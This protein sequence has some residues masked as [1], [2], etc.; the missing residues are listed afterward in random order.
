M[1]RFS[2]PR[3]L[4]PVSVVLA[5]LG[6][7][8]IAVPLLSN[9]G[10]G[11]SVVAATQAFVSA[12]RPSDRRLKGE[13]LGSRRIIAAIDQRP[14]QLPR[15]R[16]AQL[17]RL[18]L[19]L[20]DAA[21]DLEIARLSV[22]AAQPPVT[23]DIVRPAVKRFMPDPRRK[24]ERLK[25]TAMVEIET[26]L[27]EPP[28]D[29]VAVSL[30]KIA[31]STEPVLVTRPAV[32]ST[33][34]APRIALVVTAAGIN[35]ATTQKAIDGLPDGVTL[36]FA[37]IGERTNALAKA[38]IADGHT[39]LVEIPMEPVNPKRDPGEPLTLRVGN[40]GEANIARMNDAIASVPGASGISSYLGAKFSQSEDAAAPVVSEI[41]S[42]GLFLFE[43]QPSGQSRL[44]SL[45]KERDVPYAAG[46][47]AV[48]RD[49]NAAMMKDRLSALEI[50]ARREGVAIGVA[51]AY[52]D[53]I[54][55]LESWVADAER[56]GVVFVPVTRIGD[57]G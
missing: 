31:A 14:V 45:A 33:A 20:P 35:E 52:R 27:L 24:P 48:D 37:P 9:L 57:A 32:P 16:I 21:P 7:T 18:P 3:E 43:N 36:A 34:P 29:S 1:K 46:T 47:M 28:Q 11:D 5:V 30:P 10:G 17:A 15:P 51:T 12:E 40:T 19:A 2:F 54:D 39:V 42:R 23:A 49:R 55:A 41:A 38:A 6:C 4:L 13:A 26:M 56:R 44:G 22:T 53:S 25:R 8:A 50:Q